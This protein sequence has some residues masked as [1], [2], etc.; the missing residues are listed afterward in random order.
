MSGDNYWLRK[1]RGVPRRRI[2]QTSV[3]IGAVALV[4]A[5]GGSNNKKG[6]SAPANSG[7][8][9]AA[10]T[11]APAIS[12]ATAGG[13]VAAQSGAVDKIK[14][15]HYQ[16]QLAASQEELNAAKSVKRGGTVKFRYLDP[17]HFDHTRGFSCTIYDTSSLVYNRLI[18]EK[19]GPATDPFKLE[20]EPDLAEK[21]EQ[22]AQDGTEFV[23]TLRK[24]VKWQNVAPVSGR[25]FTSEDVKL[26]FER[27]AAGGVQ[28]DYFSLV[29][30]MEIPDAN[31]LRVKLKAPYVDFPAS[32]ATFAFIEPRELYVNSDK[33]QTEV[34][35]T[36]PFIRDSWTPK[37]GSVFHA[38]PDYWEMGAD[39]K[40]LPYADRV[41]AFVENST[42]TQKAGFR[43]GNWFWYQPLDTADGEDL[44]KNSPD[45]VWLD[46]PTSRGGN[47]NGFMFNMNNPK[48]KDKRVRN[49]ISMGI[50][51]QSYDDLFYDSLN[52]GFSATAIPWSF[53]FDSFPTAKSQGPTYQFNPS[54]AKKMLQAAGVDN[55]GFEIV[56]YY[57]TSGR[58]LFAPFQD[59]LRQI[60]VSVTDRHVDN[61]TAITLLANRNFNEA[62][63]MVWGPAQFSIDGWIYPW[64]VT[65]GGF[66][67]NNVA[68]SNLDQMLNAQRRE[69]DATKRKQILLQIY[70]YL[71]DQNYDVWLPQ[72]WIRDAWP[73]YVKNYRSHGFLGQGVCYACPQ[74]RSVWLDKTS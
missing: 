68:D 38:N 74:I 52:K 55:V 47:V 64:Y 56:E 50:D 29:D 21:W 7:A 1:S 57:I 39:G 51:R 3:P 62:A 65:G 67:Y 6:S 22:T 14:P 9:A 37:Q 20:L 36:G 5:C 71:L 31:T 10:G 25:A 27:Y 8:P 44:L 4:A 17:P 63:N 61:P 49:A 2:L 11:A 54:E 12:A 30:S 70:N 40:P 43:S 33:I 48:F 34:I 32:I 42:A 35:G 15:G 19:L 28:K 69:L 66:N 26:V 73:S 59:N 58:D 13:T 23:F 16:N 41:E 53:I 60:G 46:L 18:R 72:A 45:T 24:G